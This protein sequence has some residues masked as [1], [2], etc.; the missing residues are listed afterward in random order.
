[1]D[2]LRGFPCLAV[3]LVNY[4][5]LWEC[6]DVRYAV[7]QV[8]GSN[9]LS[10]SISKFSFFAF[11]FAFFFNTFSHSAVHFSLD[12]FRGLPCLAVCLVNSLKLWEYKAVRN[13][14][15]QVRGTNR[16]Y[17]YVMNETL[18]PSVTK[19]NFLFLLGNSLS[20][21][22]VKKSLDTSFDLVQ[23]LSWRKEF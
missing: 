2:W 21:G 13:T 23:A 9:R 11:A 22:E 19:F 10:L 1:M 12:W 14:L 3:C 4:L 7:S 8:R 5:K 16:F 15:I 17:K 18:F 6:N 20:V